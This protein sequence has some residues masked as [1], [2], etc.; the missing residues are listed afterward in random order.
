MK[1]IVFFLLSSILFILYFY[2]IAQAEEIKT[3]I[4]TIRFATEASYPPFEYIDGSGV[5]KG[6]D[7]DIANALCKEIKAECVFSNQPF[8]GLIPSLKVGKFDALISALGITQER[9]KQVAF[10]QAYYEPSG[11]FVAPIEKHYL[12]SNLSG[13]IVGVQQATTFEKY[14]QQQNEYANRITIKTYASI[15]EAF[16]D[17]A[18]GRIDLVLTDTP[19]AKEWLKKNDKQYAIVEKPIINHEYFG[20]GYGIAVNKDSNQ[21]LNSLNE[22]LN[23][24][25]QN[26]IYNNIMQK[27]FGK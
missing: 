20:A 19:I 7:I 4:K 6:F 21:L 25:K 1:K 22:A 17:L 15:Q 23:K 2:N 10:T 18:S 12:L 13:K 16:L 9:Q 8:S 26:G 5:I 14:L 3:E 11:S 24:I 27:Y